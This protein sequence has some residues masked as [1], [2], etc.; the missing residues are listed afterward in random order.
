MTKKR[1]YPYEAVV[2]EV[3][4]MAREPLRTA[5]K[6]RLTKTLVVVVT[7]RGVEA[8]YSLG[9]GHKPGRRFSRSSRPVI[10]F[11]DPATSVEV[12]EAHEAFVAAREA[13]RAASNAAYDAKWARERKV[14]D[15]RAALTTAEKAAAD[16]CCVYL[17]TGDPSS[18][19]AVAGMAV[20]EARVALADLGVT[21]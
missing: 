8:K 11:D 12:R 10:E 2:L 1:E 7:Q 16:A 18:P 13:K 17:T 15:A 9:D 21:R 19:I 14:R 3:V 20:C 6:A 4:G 5:A